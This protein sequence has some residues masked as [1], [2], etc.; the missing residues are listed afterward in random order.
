MMLLT[1][2]T[3]RSPRSNAPFRS[4][5]KGMSFK[6]ILQ[7]DGLFL[8]DNFILLHCSIIFEPLGLYKL[9]WYFTFVALRVIYILVPSGTQ[10]GIFIMANTS[11]F[12]SWNILCWNVRGLN[13]D[14]KWTSIKD[15]IS[16]S[17]CDI[18]CLQETKKEFIDL[19]FI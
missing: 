17:K 10:P 7:C 18:I 16:E 14:E 5:F 1:K 19:P 4:A 9:M 13:S 8:L 11:S 3:R 12:K 6:L 15:K 2:R